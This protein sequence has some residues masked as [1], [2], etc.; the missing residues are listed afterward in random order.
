[1]AIGEE[2]DGVDVRLVA[3]KCLDGL[4]RTDIPQ[5]R[6]RIA[7]TGHK[8]ILVCGVDA[9]AHHVAQVVCEL[10]DLLP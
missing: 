10:G 3:C 2:V 8:C 7:R 9:D 6:E 5:L 4:T 1:M